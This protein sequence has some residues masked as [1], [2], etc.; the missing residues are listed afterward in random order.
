VPSWI[1]GSLSQLPACAVRPPFVHLG[2]DAVIPHCVGPQTR[3]RTAMEGYYS[4]TPGVLARVILCRSV[5][6]YATPSVPLVG[7]PRFHRGAAYARCLRCAGAPRR[8]TSPHCV[9]GSQKG[10]R[11]H[12][13]Q[14]RCDGVPSSV[15][16]A[17]CSGPSRHGLT[18]RRER[19]DKRD[20]Q[21][22]RPLRAARLHAQ[23]GTKERPQGT[24]KGTAQK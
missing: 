22:R 14:D 15:I 7:T 13:R 4:S 23:A 10:T 6:T 21:P 2:V 20:G 19:Q 18:A 1:V 16:L 3:L 11:L 17:P 8:P 12:M 9:G 5:I 24:N